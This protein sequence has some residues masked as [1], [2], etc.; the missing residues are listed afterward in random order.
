M[1]HYRLRH[2]ALLLLPALTGILEFASFPR[3]GLGY[4]AWIAFV[5]LLVFLLVSPGLGY[6]FAEGCNP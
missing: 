1:P 3:L 6:A 4:L 2:V 5:P